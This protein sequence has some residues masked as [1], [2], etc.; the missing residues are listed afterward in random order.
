MASKMSNVGHNI[1]GRDKPK[2]VFITP[3]N[4]AKLHINKV[5]DIF[6]TNA[7]WKSITDA[8]MYDPFKN[9]GA[10]YNNLPPEAHKDYA[11]I[12][13]ECCIDLIARDYFTYQPL[14]DGWDGWSNHI[15]IIISNPPYSIMDKVLER[16]VELKPNCI[17]FLLA[18]H[19]ITP[20]RME[21]MEKHGFRMADME[22]CK[23]QKWY[24]MSV[25]VTWLFEEGKSCV[26]YNRTVWYSDQV[27]A[28]K[29]EAKK[30]RD[31]AKKAKNP[32]KK[33]KLL[34]KE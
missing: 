10:Y 12:L 34:I 31:E 23:V 27:W 5:V 32:K 19:A 6:N 24:G 17:S 7:G 3:T 22:L 15:D 30:K 26:G 16:A 33:I 25:M 1:K 18:L 20:K 4:L 14:F 2:D 21:Y 29:K 28:D 8:H 13:P 9:N 11:E